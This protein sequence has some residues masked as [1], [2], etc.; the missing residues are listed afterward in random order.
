MESKMG[1]SD[2]YSSST[3]GYVDSFQTKGWNLATRLT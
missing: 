2:M 3:L 1:R